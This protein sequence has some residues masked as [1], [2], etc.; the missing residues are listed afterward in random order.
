VRVLLIGINY[1][2]EESGNAPYNTGFAEHLAMRGHEVHFL[3][4]VPHYPS[5]TRGE[6]R[7]GEQNGV[8][9]HRR[10]H[11]VPRSQSAPKRALYEGTF[12]LTGASLLGLP[13]PDAVLAIVPALSDGV[14]A[15]IASRRW[16][17]PYGIVFQ[18]LMGLA[19][20]ES[21][22]SGGQ[23]VERAV[24]GTEG[25]LARDAH[26]V[27]VIAEGFRPYLEACGVDAGRIHRLRNWNQI[28]ASSEERA[29]TRA[30]LGWTEDVFVC[31]HAGNM[32]H[33]QGLES[34]LETART[35]AEAEPGL[36]FVLAGDGNR[37]RDLEAH[38]AALGLN[39][40]QFLP[41]LG[42]QDYAN[43]LAA[44][45]VLLLNQ[46]PGMKNM[47]FPG[48]ITSYV[49]SQTPIVAAVDGDSDAAKE[50]A[51]SRA[52]VVVEP[53]NPLALLVA[54]RRLR[55]DAAARAALAAAAREYGRAHL[56]PDA[57]LERW[58]AFALNL[59]GLGTTELGLARAA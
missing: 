13:R 57:A 11:F 7:S 33:K 26:S 16:G 29:E 54:I 52:A 10:W 37:R 22:V 50:L 20:S 6:A 1:A 18:D 59:A 35:A 56:T 38:A 19:A 4:G 34:I 42:R 3:A 41:S 47:A 36:R 51:P 28:P 32:G 30:R 5:W 58:E 23:R 2:P 48:K 49:F 44:A 21:G 39:N 8:H 17:V 45:D 53:G 27:A 43:V 55:Y 40:V 14:L 31:L 12:L 46:R 9:V 24:R 25:W 15:R